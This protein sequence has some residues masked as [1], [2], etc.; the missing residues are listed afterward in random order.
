M[1]KKSICFG[2]IFNGH[3]KDKDIINLEIGYNNIKFMFIRVYF[4]GISSIEI[5]TDFNKSYL[6]VFKNN[7]DLNQF[8]NDILNHC[9]YREIIIDDTKN[10]IGYVRSPPSANKKIPYLKWALIQIML[11]I[12]LFFIIAFC[13]I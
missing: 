6:L 4:Y 5:F 10:V 3:P 2:S 1:D 8:I 9:D 7:K 13:N 11:N 12:F